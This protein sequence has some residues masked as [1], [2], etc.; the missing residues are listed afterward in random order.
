MKIVAYTSGFIATVL[1]LFNILRL[2]L[3]SLK[4]AFI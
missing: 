4:H 3:H 1:F 2:S